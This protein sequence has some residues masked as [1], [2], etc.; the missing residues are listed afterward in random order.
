MKIRYHRVAL[1]T[2]LFVLLN[3][4]TGI[5]Q[6]TISPT[7]LFLDSNARFGTYL[8]INNSQDPQE[9]T[10]DF[11]FGYSVSDE[12]GNRRFIFDDSTGVTQYSAADWI[13]AF[14]RSFTLEPGNRQVVRLIVNKPEGI[15]DGTYWARIKTGS[16]AQSPPLEFQNNSD[17]VTARVG[18]KIEQVTGL[19]VKVGEVTTG[20]EV[21]EIE[22]RVENGRLIAIA[23]LNRTGNSPFLGTISMELLSDN[24]RVVNDSFAST[25]VFLDGLYRQ[26]MDVSNVT[27][28]NYQLRMRFETSRSDVSDSDI[29][30]APVV[31]NTTPVVIN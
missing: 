7:N 27:P 24:G 13:R 23:D 10:V 8:V 26:E 6:I 12:A 17:Q 25:T 30:Q 5:G 15:E 4:S 28:G 29:V 31:T 16:S 20:I 19:Y 11:L 2:V 1:F 22:T 21:K 9:I 14:P 18:F 3:F